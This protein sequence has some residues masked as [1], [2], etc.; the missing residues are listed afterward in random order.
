LI[1]FFDQ[2]MPHYGGAGPPK[3]MS[4]FRPP[5][6]KPSRRDMSGSRAIELAKCVVGRIDIGVEGVD[7]RHEPAH[8]TH[9]VPDQTV[10]SARR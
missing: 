9:G 4:D 6:I 5:S 8:Y 1:A 7:I 3:Q 10:V 2:Q